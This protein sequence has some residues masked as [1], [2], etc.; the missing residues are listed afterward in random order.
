M[1]KHT[2]FIWLIVIVF[3]LFINGLWAQEGAQ[4]PDDP[5]ELEAFLDGVMKAHLSSHNIAGAT[6]SVVKDGKLLFAKGYGYADVEKREKVDPAKTLFRTGS[7]G[8]LF[9]WT[10][11]MQLVEQGKLDLDAD[12]NTYLEGFKIPETFPQPI[13]ITH[14][15]T[16]T[17]GFEDSFLG[18]AAREPEDTVPLGKWLAEHMPARVRPP[19]QFTAY[20]NYGTALAGYI[21]ELI[22]GM[23][24]EQYVE[25][26]IFKPLDMTHTTCSQP[27]SGE[28]EKAMS[29]GYEYENGWHK[30]KP[31]E[32]FRSMGPAGLMSTTAIDMANFM[33]THLDYGKFNDI[34]ILQEETAKRMQRRLFSHDPRVNGNAHGFW[35]NRMNGLRI[36]EHGGDT[37]FFHTLMALIPGIDTGKE[38]GAICLLQQFRNRRYSPVQTLES[39]SRPVLSDPGNTPGKTG[40]GCQ[41]KAPALY[42]K[43]QRAQAFIHHPGKIGGPVFGIK[44]QCYRRRVFIGG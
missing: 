10:A 25:E 26:H 43:L 4:G 15:L 42:G 31:F 11:V 29:T 34:R 23:P 7:T 22:S 21:V 12:V 16:H 32:I 40:P 38:H 1:R 17:P 2:L 8:K 41:R 3:G 20:S 13:T 27:P 28:L 35:E 19:G 39:L 33:M 44:C 5:A 9:T 37:F 6:L 36:I 24:Y 30:E 14:L 18:M